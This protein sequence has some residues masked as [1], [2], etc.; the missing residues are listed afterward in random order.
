MQSKTLEKTAWQP[1]LDAISKVDNKVLASII[2]SGQDLGVQTETD[3]TA[4]LGISYDPHDDAVFVET[5]GLGHRI[6]KPSGIVLAHEKTSLLSIEIAVDDTRH[7][8]SFKPALE[9]PDMGQL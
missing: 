4:F 7:I 8:V 2:V 1:A 5:E 6:A 9:L 3:E